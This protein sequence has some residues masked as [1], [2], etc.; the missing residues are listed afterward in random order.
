M[1]SSAGRVDDDR[2]LAALAVAAAAP[3]PLLERSE[4]LFYGPEGLMLDLQDGPPLPA[5]SPSRAR[6]AQPIWTSECPAAWPPAASA[7]L[8]RNRLPKS[9]NHRVR[10]SRLSTT[11]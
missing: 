9:L 10:I 1:P 4:R 8:H 5:C 3:Q 6:P 7:R 11:T 2:T